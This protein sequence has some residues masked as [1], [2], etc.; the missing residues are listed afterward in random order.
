MT[1]ESGEGFP[2]CTFKEKELPKKA[3]QLPKSADPIEAELLEV[4]LDDDDDLF[5]D[6]YSDEDRIEFDSFDEFKDF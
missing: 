6:G 1:T 3:Q 2:R 4:N 5:E